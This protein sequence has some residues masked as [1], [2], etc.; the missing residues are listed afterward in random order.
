MLPS[1]CETPMRRADHV[2]GRGDDDKGTQTVDRAWMRPPGP[3]E[4]NMVL[5][6]ELRTDAKPVSLAANLSGEDDVGQPKSQ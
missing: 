5:S 1:V 3:D 2:R 4:S 6:A